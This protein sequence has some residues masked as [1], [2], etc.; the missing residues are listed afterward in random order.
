MKLHVGLVE[1]FHSEAL[2]LLKQIFFILAF[3]NKSNNSVF[4]IYLEKKIKSLKETLMFQILYHQDHLDVIWLFGLQGHRRHYKVTDVK[5]EDESVKVRGRS[6]ESSAPHGG[7][8]GT[9]RRRRRTAGMDGGSGEEL[10]SGRTGL[11][12]TWGGG[13]VQFPRFCS[14][15]LNLWL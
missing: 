1:E 7:E 13:G 3:Q 15:E 9:G 5:D 6:A 4:Y 10:K 12:E 11:M 2:K 8:D 14:G